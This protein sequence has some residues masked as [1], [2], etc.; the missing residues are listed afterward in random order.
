MQIFK[1]FSLNTVKFDHFKTQDFEEFSSILHKIYM[2]VGHSSVEEQGEGSVLYFVSQTPDQNFQTLSLCKLKTIEYRLYRKL[3]EKIKNFL[4]K[5][6]NQN[7]TKI[8][9]DYI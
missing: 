3:R 5:K 9:N 2:Q 4:A 7:Y 8:L 6:G 1:K